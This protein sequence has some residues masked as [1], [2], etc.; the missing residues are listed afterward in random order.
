[1]V[2]YIPSSDRDIQDWSCMQC[3]WPIREF[4][5]LDAHGAKE[6][7]VHTPRA[8]ADGCVN[9]CAPTCFNETHTST[10]LDAS[11]RAEVASIQNHCKSRGSFRVVPL[12]E[13]HGTRV[14]SL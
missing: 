13:Y 8:C 2:S 5:V 10:I 3:V 7:I 6:Y 14:R 9:C 4:A 1:M 11:T 12:Y